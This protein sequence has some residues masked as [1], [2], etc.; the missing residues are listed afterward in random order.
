MINGLPKDPEV[1]NLLI[2]IDL[3]REFQDITK[4]ELCMRADITTMHYDKCLNGDSIPSI[5]VLRMLASSVNQILDLKLT[6]DKGFYDAFIERMKST[7]R[8]KKSA[9]ALKKPS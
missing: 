6:Q 7:R 8:I 2:Q 4:K 3:A 1:W 5:P 9:P